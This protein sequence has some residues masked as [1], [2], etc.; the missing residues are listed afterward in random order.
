[1]P[2]D[3]V[4]KEYLGKRLHAVEQLVTAELAK[5]AAALPATSLPSRAVARSRTS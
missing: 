4:R 2:A 1:M 5:P 3:L